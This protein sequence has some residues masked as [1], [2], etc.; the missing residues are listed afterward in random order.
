MSPERSHE[1]RERARLEREAKRAAREGRPPPLAPPPTEVP[2][3][4]LGADPP[5]PPPLRTAPASARR[6]PEP[7]SEPEPPAEPE[8]PWEPEPPAEPEPPSEP[9]PPWEPEPPAE[10]EPSSEPEPPWEPEPPA[11]PE[12]SS[13]PEP[14]SEP[15]PSSEPEPP[16]REDPAP[17]PIGSEPP[18]EVAPWL[19][20]TP[21]PRRPDPPAPFEPEPAAEVDA[22]DGPTADP[23]R[24][25]RKLPPRAPAPAP[26]ALDRRSAR[27][28]A[29]Q[30]ILERRRAQGRAPDPAR[31]RRRLIPLAAACLL[32]LALAWFLVSL[33]QPF[34]GEGEGR[35]AVTI[36]SGSGVGEIADLLANRGVVASPFFFRARAT[37]SGRAGDFKAGRFSLR[38]DMSYAAA[39]DALA[40]SPAAQTVSITLPEGRAR[41]EVEDL[42]GDE[43]E[44]DYLA[45][46]KRSPLLDPADFGAKGASDLEGFLF[47]ATYELK[48]GQGARELVSQQLQA[49]KRE[50]AKVDMSFAKSKNLSRYDVLVIASMVE[51]EAQLARERPVIASVIYNRL[52]EGIPLGIDATIRFA[53]NNWTRPL[54][55]SELAVESPYN[56]RERQGLP[57]GPIGSPG[58]ASLRAAA[59]PAKTGF[60]FYVVKPNTCGEHDFSKTDTEF[61]AD[62]GRYNQER[63]ARGGK[64]PTDC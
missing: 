13:E 12:P 45:L 32:A 56:T 55:E 7:P 18:T 27:R 54:T 48:R 3:P 9:E 21:A 47:P 4:P 43:L 20:P 53:T 22:L 36:P 51:R 1:E 35:V 6:E 58:L 46:T 29:A 39:M 38:E 10:P 23:V 26:G 24:P 11:E 40:Q 57:P 59:K 49:F 25:L 16:R 63:E 8:P 15:E 44:G 60:L 28:A 61:L 34:K 50:F 62:V 5:P 2:P 42:V 52:S 19:Q 41:R 64:S 33:Y 14:P 17:P 31:R 30:S 37:V